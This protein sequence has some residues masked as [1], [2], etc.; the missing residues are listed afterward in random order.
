M[1]LI[2]EACLL[3]LVMTSI[4]Q[5]N[6]LPPVEFDWDSIAKIV[7]SLGDEYNLQDARILLQMSLTVTNNNIKENPMVPP[8]WLEDNVISYDNCPLR[9]FGVPIPSGEAGKSA[10]V[11]HVMYNVHLNIVFI[12][13]TGTSNACL[14]GLDIEYD[15]TP[16]N[17]ILNY[18]P[19]MKA[20]RGIYTTYLS[21]RDSL[22]NALR[23]YLL[24]NPRIVITGHSL[25]GALSNICALDL[26]YY[27]PINYS[28]AC[29]Q[30]FNRESHDIFQKLVTRCY[31][32]ANLSDLVT[33]APLPI[34]PNG[35]VFYHVGQLH[36][37][38]RNLGEY[39]LNHS[40]AYVLEYNIPYRIVKQ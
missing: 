8:S 6:R 24:H 26:A 33:I 31:R 21:V 32:I 15:Q 12:V 20:H 38:Q 9:V 18:G 7:P 37:F 22:L 30:V 10:V 3:N 35:E 14:V 27:K 11:A 2:Q 16:I 40:V 1:Q 4:F 19:G 39:P 36:H 23:K 34:M 13:F 29:P 17:Q 28:F 25:G 5:E